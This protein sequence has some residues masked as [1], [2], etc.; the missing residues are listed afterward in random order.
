[1]RIGKALACVAE[2]PRPE[3]FKTFQRHLDPDWIEEMLQATGT[4][5]LRRRRLPAEQVLWLVI[6]MAMFRDRSIEEVADSL[7]IALPRRDGSDAGVAKSSL[8]KARDRLGSDPL[9]W[10]FHTTASVWAQASADRHRYRGLAVYGVDGTLLR[11]PDSPQNR[12][13]FGAPTGGGGTVGA[14]PQVRAVV[15]FALC[16]HLILA[17]EFGPCTTGE[18]TYA[19]NLWSS[20]PDD[21][22]CIV[23][24]GFLSAAALIPLARDGR[25]RH[26]LIPAK[27]NTT[28]RPVRRHEDGSLEVEMIVSAAARRA[29]P[30]LPETWTVR[31]IQYQR[32]GFRPRWL[33]TSLLDA[34]AYPAQEIVELYHVRWEAEM[35]FDEIK[36]D[37]LDSEESIRSRSPERIA[38]E[39]LGILIAYNLMRLEMERVAAEAGVPPTRISFVASLHL[40]R[41]ECIWSTSASPGAIPR[42]LKKLR[43][44]LKRYILPPR[45]S[46][47]AYPRVVKLPRSGYPSKS[48]WLK[49]Q[50][51]K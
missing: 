41:D 12:K 7:E 19:R 35:A 1:M 31:A 24:S 46:E 33:I 6:G 25:G 36:T 18:L 14:Y 40:I 9:E 51:L 21:S 32:K 13:H 26:W 30:T 43:A 28:W 10:L 42:H 17:A 23:D 44:N 47:R 8:P 16:S 15:L 29:D 38:Q 45:R 3:A 37:M 5:T 4:A 34:E 50:E 11:V 2:V 22:L 48:S 39:M 49:Q 27:S 20:V